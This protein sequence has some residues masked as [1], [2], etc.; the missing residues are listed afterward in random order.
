MPGPFS[1][2]GHGGSGSIY[3]QRQIITDLEAGH[4]K[5]VVADFSNFYYKLD[6]TSNELR[7]PHIFD[8][9]SASTIQ[10]H[11]EID[12]QAILIRKR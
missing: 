3:Y 4:V 10:E 7:A 5:Y 6:G 2:P 9:I 12:G 1:A 11:R 8:Y